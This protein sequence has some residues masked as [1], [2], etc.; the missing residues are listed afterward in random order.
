MVFNEGDVLV[1][2]IA[3]VKLLAE[4]SDAAKVVGMLGRTDELVV[5]GSEKNGF[6]NVQGGAAAGWI[7]IVLVQKR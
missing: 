5:V 3:S 4:P 6:I 1:P 2:K 7:K